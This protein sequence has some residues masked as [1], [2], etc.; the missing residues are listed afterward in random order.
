VKPKRPSIAV[1]GSINTDL[2]VEV[3]RMP[4][5]G[6]TLRGR[7]VAFY[8]GGKGANQAVAAALLGADVSLYGK[9]GDDPFGKRLLDGLRGA[10]VGVGAVEIETGTASGLASIWVDAAGGNA[11]VLAAGA[12]GRVDTGYIERRLGRIVEA[13]VIL[14]Q[15]E[16]PIETVAFLLGALPPAGPLVVLDP[17]PAHDLSALP[18]SRIGVLTPNKAELRAVSGD[19]DLEAGA[20]RL[21]DA[22]V[23]DVVCTVGAEGA[24]WFAPGGSAA[25]FPAP[26]VDV[27]DTTAAGDAFAGALACALPTR[28]LEEAIP[29][30]TAAGALATTARGAQ[31]SLP[32]L[33]DVLSLLASREDGG[34]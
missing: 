17:A 13:D 21:L 16:I 1:V 24:V 26:K 9:V 27:V 18:L 25:R 19:D 15:L 30:A 5:P 11:I 12:N 32:A 23:G 28:S 3:A 14:L 34:G 8:P 4:A 20:R 2:V 33:E 10:G 6:E 22:G 29:F 31:P 7:D